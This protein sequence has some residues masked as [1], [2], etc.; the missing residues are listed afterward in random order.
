VPTVEKTRTRRFRAIAS[1][2]GALA[3]AA[4]LLALPVASE[5]G[6]ITRGG[7]SLTELLDGGAISTRNSKLTFSDF[8]ANIDAEDLDYYRF[9][10]TGSGFKLLSNPSE[11][12]GDDP[13]QLLLSYTVEAMNGQAVTEI[14]LKANGGPADGIWVSV[15]DGPSSEVAGLHTGSKRSKVSADLPHLDRIRVEEAI[16]SHSAPLTANHHFKTRKA[17][18]LRPVPEP[19]TAA[20]IGVGLLAI[21]FVE[22]RRR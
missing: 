16:D 1:G 8:S 20:L 18:R 10:P 19:G 2:G 12:G 4:V 11:I 5:A 21:G 13:G 7:L 6:R 17:K 15:S 9:F 14:G 22:R 3:L